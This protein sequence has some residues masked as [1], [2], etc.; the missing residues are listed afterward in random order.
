MTDTSFFEQL[1]ERRRT[2]PGA[3]PAP[4]FGDRVQPAPGDPSEIATDPTR[5]FADRLAARRQG[6][7]AGSIERDPLL[8]DTEERR[9]FLARQVG[10]ETLGPPGLDDMSLRA[11]LGLS[12][13]F[14]EQQL[15]FLDR[16]P[17]GDFVFVPGV[18]ETVSRVGR[19][20]TILFRRTPTEPYAELDAR[21]LENVEVLGDIA[22]LSG[23]APGVL[24]E[25]GAA[26]ATRGA[27]L[28][29]QLTAMFAANMAGELMK[30]GVEELRGFQLESPGAVIGRAGTEAGIAT[31]SGGAA[32][33]I[34]GGPLRFARGSA[35]LRLRPGA[36]QAQ[37]AAD[38]LGVDRLLPTQ[39]ANSPIIRKIGN[40]LAGTT[41]AVNDWVTR[42][43]NQAVS[44]LTRLRRPDLARMLS[45]DPQNLIDM[46]D[47]AV[48][49]IV[50]AARRG[51]PTLS[52]SG[53]ALGQGIVEY[54]ELASTLVNRQYDLARQIETPTFDTASVKAV[55]DDVLTGT[56]VSPQIGT[57]MLRADPLDPRVQ[58]IAEQIR[59][60][61][62]NL[63]TTNAG[64]VNEADSVAQLRA[65][66][67]QLWDLK[68][69]NPGEIFRQ[70]HRD[71][72]RLFSAIDQVLK[73]PT[74]A[75]PSFLTA[76]TQANDLARGRFDTLEKIIITQAGK[77]EAPAQ[78]ARKLIQPDQVDNLRLLRDTIM[79]GP[80]GVRRWEQFR[81]GA[82]G[83]FLEDRNVHNLN[84]LLDTF[85]QDTLSQIMNQAEI[86][87]LRRI[88]T[89]VEQID[90]IGLPGIAQRQS[91]AASAI[92]E[93]VRNGNTRQISD[94]VDVVEGLRPD[95]P[96][97]L[98]MRAGL[99]ENI[100]RDVV[101]DELGFN[102][103]D[104]GKLTSTLQELR[105]TGALDLLTPDDVRV[106]ENLDALAPWL[107]SG[108]DM[109]ASLEAA[110]VAAAGRGLPRALALGDVQIIQNFTGEMIE[111][112]GLGNM[113]TSKT[114]QRI[115]LGRPDGAAARQAFTSLR[116]FGAIA[117][118]VAQNLGVKEPEE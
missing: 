78:L 92:Q 64:T 22:D 11:D 97:R 74:N 50:A 2:S 59:A 66:R 104:S 52:V 26:L 109:G 8:L 90:A 107:P 71:A 93:A 84:N 41:Q 105:R 29:R 27:S 10:Q 101:N 75:S 62:P 9:A 55:A 115:A 85:D 20:S 81:A 106:L 40:Q 6:M 113:F 39:V 32:D 13:T 95:D 28:V 36:E 118:D 67:S 44:A 38:A 51:E 56:Q 102:V 96:R 87:D 94:L 116:L 45:D 12:D 63:P 31:L 37:A 110:S 46:H 99:M 18:P 69:P 65:W 17:E 79:E 111:L 49:Q 91:D 21:V 80:E 72:A 83:F 16:F 30:E 100:Y 53:T 14:E 82:R 19:G 117:G 61:D 108:G 70:Q 68:T 76:W 23:E 5:S 1:Q 48:D 89:Q 35:F 3:V 34:L 114:L 112:F 7:E 33:V 98:D 4:D 43:H 25:T 58:D 86:R 57:Q 103:V 88:A 73:N 15:K 42:Q 77:T 60:A 54:D 24:L 47:Q